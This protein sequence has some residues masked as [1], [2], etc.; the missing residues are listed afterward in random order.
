M[1][2]IEVVSLLNQIERLHGIKNTTYR[3]A[4]K[5]FN[6]CIIDNNERNKVLMN[7]IQ[8]FD[9]KNELDYY[10]ANNAIADFYF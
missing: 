6:E 4:A 7:W 5:F 8:S 3:R 1:N 2:N 9:S 10:F